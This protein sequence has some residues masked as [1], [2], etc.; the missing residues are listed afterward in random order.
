[1]ALCQRQDNF[2]HHSDT[3][4]P[5]NP[6][7]LDQNALINQLRY[8]PIIQRAQFGVVGILPGADHRTGGF[9]VALRKGTGPGPL[10]CWPAVPVPVP[11]DGSQSGPGFDPP[12]CTAIGVAPP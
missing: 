7:I 3:G 1:M 11:S 4:V 8:V 2:R 9:P 5:Y 12:P 10:G 6:A